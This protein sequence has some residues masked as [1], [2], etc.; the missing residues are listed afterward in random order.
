MVDKD[1]V[2]QGYD[3]IADTYAT[4]RSEEGRDKELLTE[5]LTSLTEPERYFDVGCGQGTP[6]LRQLSGSATAVGV[7]FS[8]RQLELAEANAPTASLIQGDMTKLPARDESFDAITAYHSIIH[9]PIEDH[10]SVIDEFARVLRADG[11]LLL[12]EGPEE[13]S[14]TNPDWLDSGVEMQWHI[15]GAETTRN[16]LETAGFSITNE[17][18]DTDSAEAERWVFFSAQLDE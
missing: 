7:D 9:I 15:A 1:V 6:V 12:T 13:W 4:E 18:G 10:Q 3:D 16:Q 11:R 8:R 2:R 5:F 14:G 17:W